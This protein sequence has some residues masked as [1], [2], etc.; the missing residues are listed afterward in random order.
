MNYKAGT[1]V[2]KHREYILLK[3]TS[4]RSKRVVVKPRFRSY[5]FTPMYIETSGLI[6][7]YQFRRRKAIIP[8]DIVQYDLDGMLVVN[9]FV[10]DRIGDEI[11]IQPKGVGTFIT[12]SIYSPCICTTTEEEENFILI[13][14][15]SS[16]MLNSTVFLHGQRNF[17]ID[18]E[19]VS[20]K[21]LLCEGHTKMHTLAW[22]SKSEFTLHYTEAD[23]FDCQWK[24]VGT[25][26]FH[27]LDTNGFNLDILEESVVP[28]AIWHRIFL[29]SENHFAT[30][31]S[32][33]FDIYT[34]L[35]W[36]EHH[37]PYWKN[38][39]YNLHNFNYWEQL[40]QKALLWNCERETIDYV[41][42]PC[43][44]TP[45]ELSKS[46]RIREKLRSMPLFKTKLT[47]INGLYK[48]DVLT[49]EK[50]NLRSFGTNNVFLFNYVSKI[51]WHMSNK[52][53][54][55]SWLESRHKITSL[56]IVKDS[57]RLHLPLKPFQEKI[58]RMMREFE[59]NHR[60]KHLLTLNTRTGLDFNAITSFYNIDHN[61]GGGILSLP[62]GTG[63]TICSLG[64]ITK[65]RELGTNYNEGGQ[66]TLVVLPLTL[67]D[68]W[69]SE[70]K[71][72]TDLDWGEIHG[73]KDTSHDKDIVFTTYGTVSSK[74]G[75]IDHTIWDGWY[76]VIFDESHQFKSHDS[77]TVQACSHIITTHRWCLTATPY[78]KGS[79]NNLH[80]HL[81][82]LNICPFNCN[83]NF[84]SHLLY[85]ETP[86]T[87][88]IMSQ[89]TSIIINPEIN[90]LNIPDSVDHTITIP[91]QYPELYT[92]LYDVIREKV[93]HAMEYGSGS[94]H[95]QLMI[96][97]NYINVCAA[98]PSIL[99]IHIWGER[100]ETSQFSITNIDDLS[101]SLS[102]RSGFAE[103]VLK[104]LDNLQETTC[105][106][107]LE[108]MTRPVI[109]DC[110]HMFCHDC[111]KR[112]LEF[113]HKCPN[114]RK[115]LTDGSFKEITP[116]TETTTVGGF[117]YMYDNL[118]RKIKIPEQIVELLK[119]VKGNNKLKHLQDIVDSRNKVVVFSQ[120]NRILESLS[121]HFD[122]H[123]IITGRSTRSQRKKNI[124]QFKTGETKVFFLS[125]KV[126]DVGINLTEADTL[127]FLEPGL[128][129]SVK[130]QTL[131]RVRRIG[132]RKTV[133]VY[134][135]ITD[136]TIE[137][138]IKV[139]RDILEQKTN[140]LMLSSA[141]SKTY[142]NRQRKH[143]NMNYILKLL[144]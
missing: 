38:K 44:M 94:R 106:L 25:L 141:Y 49:P 88:W 136:N 112:S 124:E 8:H 80:P 24:S 64:L 123:A 26:E 92:V 109:T 71:R 128:E 30:D 1:V 6:W 75:Q 96:W 114:C 87:Q 143:L 12:V 56:P 110:L 17:I 103:E 135:L 5:N 82:M 78:R 121:S 126:A 11:L 129:A 40:T 31:H 117:T 20:D 118:G 48:V 127:V 60:L 144:T 55:C 35:L 100:C 91:N 115:Y 81:T 51:L 116:N 72:F 22:V 41:T 130:A 139:E 93:R 111:I 69:I 73:R 10:V 107:C 77:K 83:V 89:L 13:D 53:V 99:P 142:K 18:H 52:P 32:T 120:Y 61:R 27:S 29:H 43:A 14:S 132:Q 86:Q 131:G 19:P 62:T 68:Q 102:N 47:R 101:A 54:S 65:C 66:R 104:T 67:M 4:H 37:R 105:C 3:D 21:Y 113:S 140:K 137:R 125:T 39:T 36:L 7:D 134:T 50:S 70:T 85:Q 63:K 97:L 95:H 16:K 9:C 34:I 119:K 59:K 42:K 90:N 79:F 28:K 23:V 74:F 46:F 122:N 138:E 84:F 108:T 2:Y 98:D 76:R 133:H 33:D 45:P 58:V 57:V 15:L